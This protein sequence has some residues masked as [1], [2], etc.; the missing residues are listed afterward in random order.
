MHLKKTSRNRAY[1]PPEIA[2]PDLTNATTHS[3]T[4]APCASKRPRPVQAAQTI[5]TKIAQNIKSPFFSSLQT[6]LAPSEE[7]KNNK[8]I[9]LRDAVNVACYRLENSGDENQA[10]AGIENIF[11]SIDFFTFLREDHPDDF[12]KEVDNVIVEAKKQ[13]IS[14]AF[15]KARNVL[16]ADPSCESKRRKS[17]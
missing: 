8:K 17:V 14:N 13:V 16:N 1:Q 3:I 15:S 10:R 6:K 9:P 11:K 7:A 4:A 5:R 2:L 12:C